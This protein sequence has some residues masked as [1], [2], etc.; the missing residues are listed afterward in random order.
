MFLF[1]YEQNIWPRDLNS[2]FILIVCLF[3]TVKLTTITDPD[4]YPYSRYGLGF[5]L[6]SRFL[7]QILV[8]VKILLFL[9]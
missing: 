5:H 2:D 3:T 9:A 7:I 4:K 1:F 8:G 6:R